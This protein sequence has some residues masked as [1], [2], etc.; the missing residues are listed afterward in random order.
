M[1][2]TG[3]DIP[4]LRNIV[5]FRVIRSMPEFKQII[6]RGTRLFPEDDKYS[7]D[8]IDFVEATRLFNDPLFDGPPMRLLRDVTDEDGHI[9]DT[10]SDEV[11]D[12]DIGSV[13]EPQGDYTEEAGGT[14]P[15]EVTDEDAKEEI[16]ASPRKF[17]VN[18]VEVVPAGTAFYIYDP[19]TGGLRLK[20]FSKFVRDQVVSLRLEPYE[21]LNQWAHVQTRKAL[22]ERLNDWHITVD[23]LAEWTG[24]P[25]ADTVD[26]LLNVA[27]QVPL[28]SRAERARRV[29]TRQKDFLAAFSSEAEKVLA[30]MLE[31]YAARGAEELDVAA[32]QGDVYWPI[33]TVVQIAGHF[34]GRDGLRSAIDKLGEF[35]YAPA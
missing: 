8:I 12:A 30:T 2:T 35:L 15:S 7:F 34:G 23:D 32:L 25:D 21:L 18:G 4:T 11:P 19:D 13:A 17:Y 29:E 9:V 22:R 6:G 10:I 26:L 5:L 3:V 1:L 28:L 20:E 14:L 33:G 27:W 16:L 31:Q 24:R